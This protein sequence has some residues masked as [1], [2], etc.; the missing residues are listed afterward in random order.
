MNG[1]VRGVVRVA[2]RNRGFAECVIL[3]TSE[4]M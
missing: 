2:A 4:D 1:D 3:R